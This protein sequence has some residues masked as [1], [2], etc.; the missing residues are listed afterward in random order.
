MKLQSLNYIAE[1][2][3]LYNLKFSPIQQQLKMN[4]EDTKIYNLLQLKNCLT[5]L[6]EQKTDQK[7]PH[8]VISLGCPILNKKLGGIK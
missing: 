2:I 1:K 8:A 5:L 6:K 4:I 3:C 7:N